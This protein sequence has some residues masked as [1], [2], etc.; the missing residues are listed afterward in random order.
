MIQSQENGERKNTL[1]VVCTNFP[2]YDFAK[3]IVGNDAE[4]MYGFL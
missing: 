4:W 2:E 3:H 1:S